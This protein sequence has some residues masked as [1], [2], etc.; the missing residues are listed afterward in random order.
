MKQKRTREAE[1]K[2]VKQLEEQEEEAVVEEKTAPEVIGQR[3][4][5][6]EHAKPA[7]RPKTKDTLHHAP[8]A[9]DDIQSKQEQILTVRP[10]VLTARSTNLLVSARKTRTTK[11]KVLPMFKMTSKRRAQG[12]WQKEDWFEPSV[13]STLLR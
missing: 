9:E 5:R 2:L 10:P 4:C 7:K 1:A 12:E 6:P 8:E 11:P 13:P 3:P